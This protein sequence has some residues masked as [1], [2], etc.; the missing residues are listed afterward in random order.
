[1]EKANNNEMDLLLRSLAGSA[2]GDSSGEIGPDP[3][4]ANGESRNHLDADELNSF[5]EG[6]LPEA[7]RSR[8]AAHLA[9][10]QSCRGIVINLSQAA[11]RTME[12]PV[13]IETSRRSFWQSLAMFLSP[14]VLRYAVPALTLTAV[15][16]I[17]LIALRRNQAPGELAQIQPSAPAISTPPQL[18]DGAPPAEGRGV[19]APQI[20][21]E[22]KASPVAPKAGTTTTE[23]QRLNLAKAPAPVSTDSA[24]AAPA[25]KEVSPPPP[26]TVANAE[27]QSR[28][29]YAPEP[30]PETYASGR[31]VLSDVKKDEVSKNQPAEREAGQRTREAY[32]LESNK[33]G[34]DKAASGL[35][36]IKPSGPRRSEEMNERRPASKTKRG[37]SDDDEALRT[38]AGKQFRRQG[39]AWV[40]TSYDSR[41]T[42]N[43]SRGS[44]SFRVLVADE[45]AIGTIARRLEGEVIVA[46]KGRAYRIR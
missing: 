36:T 6:V 23:E 34:E 27:P 41:A 28:P 15:I 20:Q 10:C 8:Y 12:K 37:S 24:T 40:D 7:A 33:E 19:V 45:P 22:T 16:A 39:N 25:A 5:A 38:V 46:W 2:R 29:A 43:L 42:V 13:A 26:P 11:G 17:S 9:D 30:K 35:Y 32:K 4:K 18:A 44:E 3:G 31:T 14:Q 21:A 1:M